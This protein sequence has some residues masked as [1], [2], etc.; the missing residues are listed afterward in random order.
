MIGRKQ[1]ADAIGVFNPRVFALIGVFACMS[2]SGTIVNAHVYSFIAPTFGAAR[3]LSTFLGGLAFLL[4][5]LCALYRPHFLNARVLFV[6]GIV[7]FVVSGA[8]MSCGATWSNGATIT[9][10][11]YLRPIA[12]DTLALFAA[13]SLLELEDVRQV[14]AVVA[15]AQLVDYAASPFVVGLLN[16]STGPLAIA[17]CGLV[18]LGLSYRFGRGSCERIRRGESALDLALADPS[19]FIAPSHA[20][21]FCVFLFGLGNGYALTL[22]EIDNAPQ[23]AGMEGFVVVLVVLYLLLVRDKRQEDMLFSFSALLIMAGLMVAPLVFGFHAG[24]TAPNTLIHLGYETFSVLLWM[25]FWG[26]GRRSFF[27]FL[28][29]VCIARMASSVG[30]DVG[31]VLGHTSNGFLPGD[32]FTAAT[33][34]LVVAFLFFAFLWVAF[35]SFSFTDTINGVMELPRKA[36]SVHPEAPLSDGEGAGEGVD[37]WQERCETIARKA[38]LTPRETEIFI[39]MARGRNGRFIMDHFTISRNTAKSHIKHVYSKL[40]V[41][42]H[43]ELID[44]AERS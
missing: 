26:I 29:V 7:S 31:A 28:P 40:G 43:Q 10:G 42:S 30:T 11:M 37:P 27:S 2:L 39:M 41:H 20:L 3:E 8:L 38:G 17:G 22:N 24:S 21:F 34:A 6:V 33:F 19:S 14:A 15:F 32:P 35:R 5:A 4:I 9:L 12:S 13:L 16:P 25:V 36:V 18:G 1:V 44:L 23:L